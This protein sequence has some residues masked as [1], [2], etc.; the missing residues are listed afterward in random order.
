MPDSECCKYR[1]LHL[2]REQDTEPAARLLHALPGVTAHILGLPRQ[3][4]I[5]YALSEHSLA[6]VVQQLQQADIALDQHPWLRWR[7]VL[8]LYSEAV[9]LHNLAEPVCSYRHREVFSRLYQH[10]P[11]GDH[12][13]TP[14]EWRLYR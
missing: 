9:Q 1:T 3:L 12:D 2:A 11:H 7:L 4:L 13:G 8:Q 14:E 5:G 6:E 10:H